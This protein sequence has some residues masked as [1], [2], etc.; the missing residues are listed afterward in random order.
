MKHLLCS[1]PMALCFTMI[2]TYVMRTHT[3]EYYQF[4]FLLLAISLVSYSNYNYL[5][6][7]CPFNGHIYDDLIVRDLFTWST[8]QNQR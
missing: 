2:R 5:Q 4:L 1:V 8:C 7:I 6:K 3:Y